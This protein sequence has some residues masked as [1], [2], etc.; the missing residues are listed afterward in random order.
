MDE[1]PLGYMMDSLIVD[2]QG[3][4]TARKDSL[5]N[6]KGEALNM[7]LEVETF[8]HASHA[9]W[10]LRVQAFIEPARVQILNDHK[11]TF[12]DLLFIVKQSA[13]PCMQHRQDGRGGS[14]VLWVKHRLLLQRDP[15]INR[16]PNLEIAPLK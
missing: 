12:H 7:A 9:N 8:S 11:P 5:L 1:A 4:T 6:L 13:S 3:R 14:Q 15:C 2:H 10:P 16:E